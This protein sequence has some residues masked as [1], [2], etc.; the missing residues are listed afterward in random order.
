M[1]LQVILFD[2]NGTLIDIETDENEPDIY[3]AIELFLSY[4][5][6]NVPSSELSYAYFEIVNRQLASSHEM[7]PEFNSVGVWREILNRYLPRSPFVLSSHRVAQLPH[8]LSELQ[9]G[10]SRKRFELYPE[11]R[12]VL[13]ELKG[14]YKLAAVTD[15]QSTY[16]VPELETAGLREYFDTVVVSGGYGYRKPDK[17][18][19]TRAL[20][21]LD[22]KPNQAI[23]V[24]NDMHRD[25]FGAKQIG[26]KTVF[27]PTQFG[28]KSYEDIRADYN[29]YNFPQLL[30]AIQYLK[31]N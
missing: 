6:I 31:S 19:F 1:D 3:R 26:I 15:A 21:A 13:D 29:I 25:I 14:Q 24:G 18:L 11:V 10:L 4:Q 28:E 23:F 7:Y 5:G 30:E 9:R 22:L 20:A 8:F 2:V 27:F 16:A 12:C 17:R